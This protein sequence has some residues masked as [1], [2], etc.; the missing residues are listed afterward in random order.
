[1][2]VSESD[3]KLLTEQKPRFNIADV[4]QEIE[5]L[6]WAGINFGASNSYKLQ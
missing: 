2:E 5:M 6:E 3:K 4:A 1:M